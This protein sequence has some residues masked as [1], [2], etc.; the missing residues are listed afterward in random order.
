MTDFHHLTAIQ[1]H[2][3]ISLRKVDKRWAIAIVVRPLTRLSSAF[4]IS[5]SVVVSTDDV[6][7]SHDQNARINQ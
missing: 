2:Q 3:T 5:F 1:Y 6:A 4:W 7:S